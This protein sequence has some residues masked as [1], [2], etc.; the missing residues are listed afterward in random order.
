MNYTTPPTPSPA[1]GT[2]RKGE[3]KVVLAKGLR[4]REIRPEGCET[5]RVPFNTSP[6]RK[7]GEYLFPI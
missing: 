6:R 7:P 4:I 5:Y 3:F 2:A 1:S